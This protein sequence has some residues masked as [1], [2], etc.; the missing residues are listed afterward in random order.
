MPTSFG[1]ILRTAERQP[2]T[3]RLV[4]P[5]KSSKMANSKDKVDFLVQ[6]TFFKIWNHFY[7]MF[8]VICGR[9]SDMRTWIPPICEQYPR[10]KT[11]KISKW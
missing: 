11:K 7:F 4:K 2:A 1:C 9:G 8:V 5:S 3:I 10:T 6:V